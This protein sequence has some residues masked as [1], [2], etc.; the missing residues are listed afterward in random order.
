MQEA[1]DAGYRERSGNEEIGPVKK[2]LRLR[3]ESLRGYS[4]FPILRSQNHA[5]L[6][7]GLCVPNEGYG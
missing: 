4:V 3:S 1:E 6:G 5:L 2:K 7:V